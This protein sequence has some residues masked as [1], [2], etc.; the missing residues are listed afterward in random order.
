MKTYK[1]LYPRIHEFETLYLAFLKARRGKRKRPDVAAFE[2]NLEFELPRLQEE[3]ADEK[4]KGIANPNALKSD[5]VA[6]WPAPARRRY[7]K[8]LTD[9]ASNKD[10]SLWVREEYDEGKVFHQHCQSDI[11]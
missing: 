9:G 2:F 4:L 6:T 1:R 11:Q 8:L 7:S 10:A 5:D 3:L